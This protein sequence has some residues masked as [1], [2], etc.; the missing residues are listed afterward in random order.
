MFDWL[1]RKKKKEV[2]SPVSKAESAPESSRQMPSEDSG[3]FATSMAVGMMTDNALLGYAAGGDISGALLGQAM[4]DS[5]SHNDSSGNSSPSSSDSSDY[6]SSD[7]SD[8][9]D[10][11]SSD[12][13][14]CFDSSS[15]SGSFD[16]GGSSDW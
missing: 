12:D 7:S 9:S 13:S 3:D 11:G 5:H 4:A 8:S 2:N 14:S 10:Y 15:D 16:S 1:R 6:D